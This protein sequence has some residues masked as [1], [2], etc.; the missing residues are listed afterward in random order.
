[1]RLFR[2][3]RFALALLLILAGFQAAHAA[4]ILVN[5]G[6]ESNLTSWQTYG[7]NNYVLTDGHAHTGSGYYKVYGQF[8]GNENLT[9]LYQNISAAP[10]NVYTAD[11]WGFSLSADGGGIHGQ[12][13]ATTHH[14]V[15]AIIDVRALI[16]HNAAGIIGVTAPIKKARRIER[17]LR[18]R[19]LP[20]LPIERPFQNW[21]L[22]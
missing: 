20:L 17:T 1:M 13:I 5:P 21:S 4:N 11:G 12:G 9:G 7:A 6:F 2:N 10:G 16:G 3:N 8:N 19:A 15:D 14:Q 18:C 22:T